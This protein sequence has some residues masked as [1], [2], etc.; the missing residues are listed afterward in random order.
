MNWTDLNPDRVDAVVLDLGG[1]VLSWAFGKY[2]ILAEDFPPQLMNAAWEKRLGLRSGDM[3]RLLWAS[4]LHRRAEIGELKFEDFWPMVGQT[5][6]L[7]A[8]GL[9][10]LFEDYW[11]ICCVRPDV[12]D[13]IHLLRRR[14][15][16]GAL[17]NAWSN[18]R[19][20]VNRRYAL[21]RLFDFLVISAE[22]GVAKPDRSIY[23]EAL[24]K[25]NSPANRVVYVDDVQ[26]NVCA[27]ASAGFIAMQSTTDEQLLN[28]LQ[29]LNS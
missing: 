13:A 27:A 10:E 20:E 17:S 12:T 8:D 9:A 3:V 16:V 29:R 19:S 25:T 5:L 21:D 1:V 18:A 28:I 24:R 11:S 23:L 15:R 2:R 14:Y 7:N 6:N 26:E 22:F 4:E